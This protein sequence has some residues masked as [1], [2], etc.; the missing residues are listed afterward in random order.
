MAATQRKRT[1]GTERK[2]FSSADG[3]K[4]LFLSRE[5]VRVLLVKSCA[6]PTVILRGVIS[7]A[8]PGGVFV[9]A[10]CHAFIIVSCCCCCC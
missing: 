1:E 8:G 4:G 3:N 5:W 10:S 7:G 2:S 9:L 6:A